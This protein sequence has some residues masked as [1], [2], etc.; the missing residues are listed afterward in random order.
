MADI[1]TDTVGGFNAFLSAQRAVPG[2]ATVTL[3]QFDSQGFDVLYRM[4]PLGEA[5]DLTLAQFQPRAATPLLDAMVRIINETGEGLKALSED[6]RPSQ[7]YLVILTDGMENASHAF[8]RDQ[9]FAKVKHQE[10]VYKWRFVYLGANQDAIAVG[11]S[12]GVAP[13][14]SINYAATPQGMRAAY[15]VSAAAIG[16]ARSSGIAGASVSYTAEEREEAMADD[17]SLTPPG[18]I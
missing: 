16:R 18:V 3:A 15:A 2:T 14:A 12:L 17:N 5:P 13:A 9:V 6:Q 8:T 10:D 1:A 11:S 4:R 7:V